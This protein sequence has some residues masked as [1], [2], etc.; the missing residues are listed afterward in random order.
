MLVFNSTANATLKGLEQRVGL[1]APPG[2]TNV[3]FGIFDGDTS[4]KWDTATAAVLKFELYADPLGDGTGVEPLYDGTTVN[5]GNTTTPNNPNFLGA[6]VVP[7]SSD[8]AWFDI[9]LPNSSLALAGDGTY[10][11]MLIARDAGTVATPSGY[12]SFKVRTQGTAGLAPMSFTFG[13]MAASVADLNVMSP[14]YNGSW[15]FAFSVPSATDHVVL[16]DGDLDY[17]SNDT[18]TNCSVLPSNIVR[19]T[20]DADTPAGVFPFTPSYAAVSE[21]VASSGIGARPCQTSNPAEDNA[22]AMFA[23]PVVNSALGKGVGYEL[24]TPDGQHFVNLNPSGNLE[25]EQFRIDTN[26]ANSADFYTASL[27]AGV[28]RVNVDGVDVNNVNAWFL[29]QYRSLA[30]DPGGNPTPED[31]FYTIRGLVYNDADR[32]GTLTTPGESGLAAG[33]SVSLLDSNGQVVATT[34]TGNGTGGLALGE[35]TFRVAA[36]TYSVQVDSSSAPLAGYVATSPSSVPNLQVSSGAP[37]A[38]ADFGYIL[39]TPPVA[40]NDSFV[41][42]HNGTSLVITTVLDNDTDVDVPQDT[43]SIVSATDGA[44][45]TTSVAGNTVQWA[46]GPTFTGSDSFT[47]TI[48]DGQP[49][50]TSTATVTIV[51]TNAPPAAADD[52]Y[53]GTANTPLT[54]TAPGVEQNDS[55]SDGDAITAT[56]LAPSPNGAVVLNGD[57]S[58]TFTPTTGFSGVTTF[59][60]TV[61]DGRVDSAA[62]TVTITIRKIPVTVKVPSITTQFDGTEK[63]TSCEVSET[64][65]AATMTYEGPDYGPT[66]TPPTNVGTYTVTCTYPGDATHEGPV[67]GTGTVTINP[68]PLTVTADP[69]TKV[70]GTSDP[71]L[72]Y[73]LTAGTL[74]PGDT[75]T[76][77]VVRV[78]GENVGSYQINQ[79]TVTAGPNYTVTYVPAN[80]DIT[81]AALTITADPQTKEFGATDPALTYQL[82]A[83]VLQAGDSFSGGLTRTAGEGVG[84]YPIGQGT[85]IV[86]SNYLVT[87]VPANLT[88]TKKPVVV[89][90]PSI[91]VTYDGTPKPTT[92]QVTDSLTAD[93]MVYTGVA[94]TN[95]GP[96]TTAPT[97]V[98]TYTASCTFPGDGN[99]DGPVTGSGT[100]TITPAPLTITAD[101]KTKTYGSSDP[102]LTYKVTAGALASGDSLSGS[103]TRAAEENVGA[104]AI[105]QGSVT[106]GSNYAITYVSANLT[107]TKATVTVTADDKSKT[108]G[109]ANPPL[110]ASYSGFVLGQTLTTSGITGSPALA[111]SATTSSPAGTYPITASPGTL[112]STNYAFAFIN[113]VLTVTSSSTLDCSVAYAS[114]AQLWPPNHKMVDPITIKG[115]KGTSK[116]ITI[117]IKYIWQD[118]PTD[119]W[120]D[121]AFDID[122]SGVGTSTA[123]VRR[124]RQGT[125]STPPG[126]G[127]V[128]EIG[129]VATAGSASCSGKV[130]VGIPHDQGS[131]PRPGSKFPYD[132]V[133]RWDS[134]VRAGHSLNGCADYVVSPGGHGSSDDGDKH[135]CDGNDD[136]DNHDGHHDA[137]DHD[138]RRDHPKKSGKKYADHNCDGDDDDDNHDGRHDAKDHDYRRDHPKKSVKKYADH[139]CDGDDDD[140]NH[141]GRHD[142]KDHDYRNSHRSDDK[143][144]SSYG[145][146]RDDDRDD[147]GK[148]SY[149]SDRDDDRNGDRNDD[150]KKGKK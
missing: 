15:T 128:Y 67:T 32:S 145:N 38:S 65:P 53:E 23:K 84:S 52:S 137:K 101:P 98:G 30:L 132:S 4:G 24:V 40:N 127:R 94:P 27:P 93:P 133:C 73:Q 8:N 135:N 111:T 117:T 96:S 91:T 138:Y 20:D 39:N 141:D 64:A 90:V 49:G 75:L 59:T 48:T 3:V 13:G 95:Y 146:D 108:Q 118:E 25:W 69:K 37:T 143:G 28:Y 54:L 76:G 43:L 35:Y 131:D 68:A 109:S 77:S 26:T 17:G 112:A 139:D 147:H 140:D 120:G 80:L 22:N 50:H 46:K 12:T 83:G 104:Y 5:P 2:S 88:I 18:S 66:A 61:S 107:I 150:G 34:N 41:L 55:D 10:R 42:P 89:T 9:S 36:G 45:G 29:P 100:V 62:A 82:T 129:F 148:S 58:F 116:P 74:V 115:V 124:E 113:G 149:G 79:G 16:W 70:Y 60:Y 123:Y 110:T 142:A 86:S 87:Y 78:P 134:T 51:E 1:T 105:A 19:D 11:Y 99:H 97:S 44:H 121:G 144:K 114:S 21:G 47:Y 85:V 6:W 14:N 136:D 102:A 72:T 119:S 125:R 56:L 57:G 130:Y 103:L 63:P 7:T 31:A 81:P 71:A 122:G 92:C 33:V 106:A 126:D